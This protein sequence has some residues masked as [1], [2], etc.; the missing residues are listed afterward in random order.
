MMPYERSPSK[1]DTFIAEALRRPEIQDG[2]KQAELE[3]EYLAS[4]LR[5]KAAEIWEAASSEIETYN[6]LESTLEAK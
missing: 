5:E 2:V 4:S 1:L 6:Q 3:E